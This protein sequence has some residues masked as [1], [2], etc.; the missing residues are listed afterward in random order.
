MSSVRN[1]YRVARSILLAL[2]IT[3]ISLYLFLYVA[4]AIPGV[5][6]YVKGIAERE[7]SSYLKGNV[8]IGRLD[9]VPFS[10]IRVF[11]LIVSDSISSQPCLQVAR[12]GA[13]VELADLIFSRRITISY[14]EIS[15]MRADISQAKKD[16]PLNIDFIIKA[17]APKDKNKPPTR[18][19]LRLRKVAIRNGS[20]SF[21]RLWMPEKEAEDKLDF[22]HL[23]L[24][25]L[26]LDLRIPKLSNDEIEGEVSRLSFNINPGLRVSDV[27]FK[28]L[29]TPTNLDVY[30]LKVSL[31][32]SSLVIPQLSLAYSSP[33]Q[34]KHTLME[35]PL[36]LSIS[37]GHLVLSEL[38]SIVPSLKS[39][40]FPI[41]FSLVAHGNPKEVDN[42]ELA[43]DI[44]DAETSLFLKGNARELLH[45]EY[46]EAEFSELRANV[47][48]KIIT[49]LE[50]CVP[51]FGGFPKKIITN[52]GSAAI[53]L[54]GRYAAETGK[55]DAEGWVSSHLGRLDFNVVKGKGLNAN[56]STE[57]FNVGALLGIGKLGEVAFN[58]EAQLES[59]GKFSLSN[60]PQ[61]F[62]ALDLDKIAFNGIT[63]RD[64][65]A[66]VTCAEHNVDLSLLSDSTGANMGLNA[67][68]DL[69]PGDIMGEANIDINELVPSLFG[70]MKGYEGYSVSGKGE[71]RFI[72]PDLLASDLM[73]DLRN[74]SF[75]NK[76]GEGLKLGYLTGR[77]N[78]TENQDESE[79]DKRV[80][81]RRDLTIRS[82]WLDIDSKIEDRDGEDAK[83]LFDFRGILNAG[84]RLAA[85]TFP[86][87]QLANNKESATEKADVSI[88]MKAAPEVYRFWNLPAYPLGQASI[89][90]SLDGETGLASF[91][92]DAPYIQ[93]GR[94]VLIEKTHFKGQ[95]SREEGTFSLSGF[96]HYPTKKGTLDIDL[97]LRGH[98]NTVFTELGFRPGE[99][100]L[101]AGNMA[102][103]TYLKRNDLTNA[104][105]CRV[106]FIPSVLS[107]ADSDWNLGIGNMEWTGN[108]GIINNFNLASQS[109]FININGLI[110][111][112]PDDVVTV[113][114]GG[115]DL[116][117]VFSILNINYV[118]FGGI[119]TGELTGKGVL[120]SSPDLKTKFLNIEDFSYNSAPLGKATVHS[121]FDVD[122]KKVGIK[123]TV[124]DNEKKVA[125]IDGGIWVTRDSLSFGLEAHEINAGFM[126]PFVAAFAEDVAGRASGEMKLFGTFSD[127]DL[128]GR[129]K[130]DSL[131][132][133]L[134]ST[135][136]RYWG[137]D[138]IFM[139]SGRIEIPGFRL[140]DKN[141]NSALLSGTLSHRYFHDPEFDFRMSE[142]NNLLCYDTNQTLNPVWYGT[143]YA[144]GSGH[145][146]GY[147]GLVGVDVDMVSDR[148]STFTFVLTDR[149]EAADYNF[150]TFIDSKKEAAK[151][152]EPDTIPEFLKRFRKQVAEQEGE[153]TAVELNF[154]ASVN[155]GV[156][157]TLIMDPQ[158]GDK[159]TT[160][161]SGALQM[162]YNSKSEDLRMYGKYT[163]DEGEYN[164]SLQDI[165]LKQFS[166]RPGSTISF[167]GDPYSANLD[168]AA[169][170]RVNANL[171]DL[172]QS[173]ANDHELTRTNVPV[174]AVMLVS[175]DLNGPEITFDVE[176]P[177][178]TTDVERKVKSLMSTD[179]LL[180]RQIIYLLALN[181]FYTP[182]NGAMGNT[183]SSGGTELTSVASSTI[184]SHLS[185]ILSSMTDHLMVAPSFRS[186][187][188][189][190]SDVEV[191][192]GLSSRLLDNRL[193][194]N[195]NLGYR[196]RNVSGQSTQLIGDFDIEYLLNKSGNLRLKAYNRF[197]DQNY[198]LRQALTTQGVGLVVRRDFDNLFSFLRPIRRKLEAIQEE[199]E[200]KKEKENEKGEGKKEEEDVIDIEI[201]KDVENNRNR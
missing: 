125:D 99:G 187:K 143:I 129:A 104:L 2:I 3:V 108:E 144:S 32:E 128:I 87:L 101:M 102:F 8:E 159:I 67:N 44:P 154:R 123:A 140:Y 117:Y 50:E 21:S 27:T 185:N 180:S 63:L 182:E 160:R 121:W 23:S 94:N 166:I 98:N 69:Y 196:D 188:G 82:P 186:D 68:L 124:T 5:Q 38:K 122:Q 4:L 199:R 183:G 51:N 37:Q 58:A 72:G 60:L 170:Y 197:N 175:G 161:G 15:G 75:L 59:L 80:A 155:P 91:D 62:V 61:G 39:F 178:L 16:G 90:L 200:D 132:L 136:V 71:L 29:Y 150:L 55:A 153:E 26:T 165:I 6:N 88:L 139:N 100:N 92:I 127:I 115:I 12:V 20:A 9:I 172:D 113:R 95:M 181:R 31:E 43:L 97:N 107:I 103:N 145:L 116:D 109:Q 7:L 162:S 158:A 47:T 79:S 85:E 164:F 198:Y 42:L 65:S 137:S 135:N 76:E 89:A 40:D 138:S 149:E 74:L 13:A 176:L 25:S 57:D 131:S 83:S 120:S 151:K 52:L 156:L 171:T 41:D 130:A 70:L 46:L 111:K 126:S 157:V 112:D 148:N 19:N 105:D 35:E 49:L 201:D 36:Q 54:K 152:M 24:N 81:Y 179:D 14:A 146:Y 64:I 134:I 167:N 1:I 163:L 84:M 11:D 110:S 190:F 96:T 192:L 106:D 118:T 114:L 10:E 33:D 56:L 169:T 53:T 78:Y 18:F 141:G 73:L 194:I 177:T 30:D 28:V 195:G 147:P 45:P 17:F 22:N 189:D 191:D 48:P 93:Q 168:I 66:E 193:L 86:V 133:K 119:A 174:D 173:F 142:A 77:L 184:S 34:I